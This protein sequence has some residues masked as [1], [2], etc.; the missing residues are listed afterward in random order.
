MKKRG[1]VFIIAEAGVNHNGSLATAKKM[2]GAASRA[3]ADAIKF[4]TFRAEELAAPHAPK[5]EYQVKRAPRYETQLDMLKALELDAASHKEL[6]RHCKDKSIQFISSPFDTGSVDMLRK[7][8]CKIFKIPSGE[9]TDLPLLRKIGSL[10]KQ[11]ILST[12]MSDLREVRNALDI[13]T[14]SGTPRKNITVLH[15]TT[16]YPAPMDDVNLMAMVT[17]GNA[18]KVKVGYSDHTEGIEVPVAAVALGAS[19][20]EKHFTMDRNMAGPDHKASLEPDGLKAMV[21]AIRNIEAALGDGVKFPAASELRNLSAARKSI[22]AA[23]LIRKGTLFT[24]DNITAKRPGGGIE[25]VK[26]DKVLGRR[27]RYDFTKDEAIRL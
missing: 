20:I 26:W 25:P 18:L 3:G 12:G 17:I 23:S 24:K 15:C 14:R 16:E 22:V 27:A 2:I 19:V 8:G 5:A 11:I 9:I 7:I 10:D 21:R 13:L 4:Q 6:I 1:K